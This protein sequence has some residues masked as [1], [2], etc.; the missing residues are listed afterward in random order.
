M[1]LTC[2]NI[3]VFLDA[4]TTV[5]APE[6]LDR[7]LEEASDRLGYE[8]VPDPANSERHLAAIRTQSWLSVFDSLSAGTMSGDLAELATQLSAVACCPVLVAAVYD[9]DEFA[10]LLYESGKQ[11]DGFASNDELV[12]FKVNKWSPKKRVPEWSR[13]FSKPLSAADVEGLVKPARSPFADEMLIRLCRLVGLPEMQATL[14]F[15]DLD[16][17]TVPARHFYF[18]RKIGAASQNSLVTQISHQKILSA[19]MA[20]Q[21]LVGETVPLPFELS[22]S[23]RA[24][25]NPVMEI[26]GT[27]VDQELV[28][29]PEV[30][31]T[32]HCGKDH[33]LAGGARKSR[34]ELMIEEKPG[35][36]VIRASFPELS[37]EALQA[38]PKPQ[39]SLHFSI[40][41]RG[42]QTR[43]RKTAGYSF[44][45]CRSRGGFA[46]EAGI[47][48]PDTNSQLGSPGM[49]VELGRAEVEQS[50]DSFRR[51]DRRGSR[52]RILCPYT[53]PRR[54]LALFR[55][56]QS[57]LPP[58]G[59]L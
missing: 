23:T 46:F 16:R 7:L 14:V 42:F 1:G 48:D 32:W 41:L 57:L 19:P 2:A 47:P 27:A 51:S 12:P 8:Q 4:S 22:A 29:V 40:G 55:G 21:F 11:V 20:L 56:D 34:A 10:F 9:S 24:L 59:P 3:H 50:H 44:A 43:H 28:I 49:C 5:S 15:K 18:R 52:R 25:A 33:L 45:P 13:L 31:A 17:Q 53:Y 35:R 38:A 36:R 54:K 30:E 6:S 58:K 37:P 26:S 39:I